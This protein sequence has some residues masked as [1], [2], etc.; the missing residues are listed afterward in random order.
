MDKDTGRTP[1]ALRLPTDLLARR[2]ELRA[3]QTVTV[4]RNTRIA[5]AV[6]Q[7]VEHESNQRG[8]RHEN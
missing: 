2:D 5:A 7:R 4:L 6:V 3:E 8:E 1:V